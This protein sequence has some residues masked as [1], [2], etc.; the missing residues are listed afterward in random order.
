VI[1][2]ALLFER[3]AEAHQVLPGAIHTGHIAHIP[4]EVTVDADIAQ[5]PESVDDPIAHLPQP[6]G[7][8]RSAPLTKSFVDANLPR[9][10]FEKTLFLGFTIEMSGT[11]VFS[12]CYKSETPAGNTTE[13]EMDAANR[14]GKGHRWTRL[15]MDD[16]GLPFE[17]P[18]P[19][20]EI[21]LLQG[22]LR[23]L[24]R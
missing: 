9:G 12:L 2:S 3:T 18:I 5:F 6:S 13:S 24:A 11:S 19:A 15:F 21:T 23:I 8:P 1:A 14:V 17:A 10:I 20:A 16:L 22:L 4:D 7:L